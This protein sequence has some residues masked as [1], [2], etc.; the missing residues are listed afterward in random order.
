MV[1]WSIFGKRISFGNEALQVYFF[2][3]SCR[4]YIMS[5]SK[6]SIFGLGKGQRGF[7]ELESTVRKIEYWR[8]PY[9]VE[10]WK[11]KFEC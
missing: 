2:K 10:G 3:I 7:A 11:E 4:Y 9:E 6:Q 8:Y 1:P 5:V